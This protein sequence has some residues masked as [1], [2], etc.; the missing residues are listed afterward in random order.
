MGRK[1]AELEE[2]GKEKRRKNA[3]ATLKSKWH[4]LLKDIRTSSVRE[5]SRTP[6]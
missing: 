6:L 4:T 2:T 3:H 5:R 1:K